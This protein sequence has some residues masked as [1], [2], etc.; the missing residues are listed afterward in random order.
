MSL[1]C[2]P[3]LALWKLTDWKKLVADPAK[4]HAVAV[5]HG[6]EFRGFRGIRFF[7]TV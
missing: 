3:L 2:V 4:A 1:T 6:G 5:R 7:K